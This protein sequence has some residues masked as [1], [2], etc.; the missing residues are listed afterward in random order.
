MESYFYDTRWIHQNWEGTLPQQ[1]SAPQLWLPSGHNKHHPGKCLKLHTHLRSM[2]DTEGKKEVQ[3][4]PPVQCRWR[5]LD[6][7]KIKNPSAH[8]TDISVWQE[9]CLPRLSRPPECEA[10]D[11]DKGAEKETPK[12]KTESGNKMCPDVPHTEL[13]TYC[14]S[15]TKWLC[16]AQM[17]L[18]KGKTET[19]STPLHWY[20]APATL[21]STDYDSDD[22]S[23]TENP[24]LFLRSPSPQ[25]SSICLDPFNFGREED[26]SEPP[27]KPWIE[28]WRKGHEIVTRYKMEVPTALQRSAV[29]EDAREGWPLSHT[30][31]STSGTPTCTWRM[32]QKTR[33]KQIM[34][35]LKL[36]VWG[37]TGLQKVAVLQS[38][39]M[40]SFAYTSN[41]VGVRCDFWKLT[42]TLSWQHIYIEWTMKLE[43]AICQITLAPWHPASTST[44]QSVLWVRWR[45][46]VLCLG[47][48]ASPYLQIAMFNLHCKEFEEQVTN[49]KVPVSAS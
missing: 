8:S 32:P 23:R 37:K 46:L 30:W 36:V 26:R 48:R 47:Q 16:P 20:E 38:H 44:S 42:M 13:M 49:C 35:D 33:S 7:W 12:L 4:Y 15:T 27:A 19:P 24:G 1:L 43:P 45:S 28:M 21:D 9:K 29:C 5:H 11:A 2:L 18:A 10:A 41:C 3:K 39:S 25:T 31:D 14:P 22:A 6:K 17:E 34:P 40:P